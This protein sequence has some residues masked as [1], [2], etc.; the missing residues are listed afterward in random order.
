M[1]KIIFNVLPAIF[2]WFGGYPLATA[3]S[4]DVAQSDQITQD[5]QII[6]GDD[7]TTGTFEPVIVDAGTTSNV[8]VQFPLTL[9]NKQVIIQALDGGALLGV[10]GGFAT[11]GADGKLSFQFQAANQAGLY[12]VLVISPDS[13]D[14]GTAAVVAIVQFQTP[15]STS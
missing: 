8:T 4:P 2:L 13:G 6:Q 1:K 10:N 15:A 12:R 9:A 11:V 5:Q 14:S 7:S 3:Q